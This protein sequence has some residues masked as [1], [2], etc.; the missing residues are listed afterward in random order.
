VEALEVEAMEFRLQGCEVFMFTDNST[1]EAAFFRGTSSSERLFDL[2][3]QLRKLELNHQCL[4]HVVHVAGTRMIG[5]GS[6]GLSRG[7]LMEG[8]MTGQSMLSYVPLGKSAL[9]RSPSLLT[10]IQSWAGDQL[11]LLTPKDW[12]IRGQGLA[13]FHVDNKGRNV[14]SYRTGVFLWCPPPVVAHVAAEEMRRSRHKREDSFHV[15]MCPRLM[16]NLWRKLVLKEVDF[17]FEV[18]VGSSVWASSMHEPLLIGVCLPYIQHRPWK[19]GNTPKLLGMA[20]ELR[21]VWES[22]DGDP[23]FILRQLFELPGR[24]CA[25]SPKLVRSVLYTV[26]GGQV[27]CGNTNG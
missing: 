12:F 18:P 17:Y 26:S 19:L 11:E 23:G 5:Q 1:A 21:H 10:W 22:S 16:T 9:E 3:L 15:F 13:E 27:S 4:I 24:L 8:V 7:N 20:R 2:V 14:A 6:D 25:L